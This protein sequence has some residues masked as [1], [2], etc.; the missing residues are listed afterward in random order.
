MEDTVDLRKSSNEFRNQQVQLKRH[1][2]EVCHILLEK[3]YRTQTKPKSNKKAFFYQIQKTYTQE[4]LIKPLTESNSKA[5]V[6]KGLEY[7]S[8][9]GDP[10]LAK[11]IFMR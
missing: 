7:A 5:N 8:D 2:K 9:A 11:K 6:K 3:E 10:Y 4:N 1:L